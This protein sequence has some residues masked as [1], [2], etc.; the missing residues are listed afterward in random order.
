MKLFTCDGCGQL[1]YFE[2]TQCLSCGRRLGYDPRRRDMKALDTTG[3]GFRPVGGGDAAFFC[4]NAAYDACNWLVAE[5]GGYCLC[6]SHNRTVPNLAVGENLALWRRLETAKHQVMDG[7]DAL[8]LPHPN[9]EEDPD[10]GL[11]F[12]F[13]DVQGPATDGE[14]PV[15][16]GHDSGVITIALHEADDAVRE[17]I[18]VE[19]GEPYRSLV[20]HF[21]H[22]IGHW[23]FDRLVL[24]Y[25]GLVAEARALFGDDRW[26]Y[27]E[28]L[29]KHYAEGAPPDWQD[30]HV[31]AYATAHP[32]ED[33]AETF[34]H[35]LHI[36]DTLET[37][38]AFGLTVRPRVAGGAEVS[39][40]ADIDPTL[41]GTHFQALVDRWLPLTYAVN[42]LNRS[43]GQPDLYPF[44][45]A[46]MV[47]EKL[48]FVH[49]VVQAAGR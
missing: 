41:D 21:R 3:D 48:G 11:A 9:R 17:R 24:P 37:A 39:A 1:I 45:I 30:R 47:I 22:E 13:L 29:K 5:P 20:G 40:R 10:N 27:T 16:T 12:D 38:H 49:K 18:R 6:C 46:P 25:D 35:Y 26:D 43:M 15:M 14:G 2:N 19:M 33:W 32:F 28:A 36:V 7:I 23:Y 42:S 8:Q 4:A 31:S 34:A 44:V